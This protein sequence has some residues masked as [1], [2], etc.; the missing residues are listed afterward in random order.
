MGRKYEIVFRDFEKLFCGCLFLLTVMKAADSEALAKDYHW[1]LAIDHYITL[2]CVSLSDSVVRQGW[3]YVLAYI[4]TVC[5]LNEA[6][7]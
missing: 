3:R 7:V 4:V 2:L 1:N 6:I 5:F